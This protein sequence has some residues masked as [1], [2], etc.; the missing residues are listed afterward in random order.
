MSPEVPLSCT[1]H[2]SGYSYPWIHGEIQESC[3]L[4]LTFEKASWCMVGVGGVRW[5]LLD[6]ATVNPLIALI[7]AT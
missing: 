2:V 4:I 7:F 3:D 5:D 6:M 1:F